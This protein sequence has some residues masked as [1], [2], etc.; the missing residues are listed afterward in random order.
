MLPKFKTFNSQ[1]IEINRLQDNVADG[2]NR[3]LTSAIL[4][5]TL[6]KSVALK[7]GDNVVN[8]ELGRNPN[9]WIVVRKRGPGNF[10]DKQDSNTTPAL[11][12]VINS[13][14]AV[15]VDFYFF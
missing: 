3:V 11:N 5:F 4:D 10:Y 13:D 2:F 6:I 1:D 8:H 7:I 12:I 9:G 15:T 14:S